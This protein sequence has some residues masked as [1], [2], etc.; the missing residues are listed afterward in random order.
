MP[1]ASVPRAAA[2]A[3]AALPVVVACSTASTAIPAPV[4]IATTTLLARLGTDTVALE[5]YTRTATHMEGTLVTRLPATRIS[6]Y[7]VEFGPNGAPTRATLS[8]RDGSGA[9]LSGGLQSLS[10]RFGRDSA[11]FVGHRSASD[12]SHAFALRGLVLPSLPF[13]Y[14]L[15]EVGLARMS[16]VA[17][18]SIEFAN[19]PLSF[20]TRQATPQAV[21]VVSHDSVRITVNG[22]PLYVRHDGR[23]GIVAVDGARTTFKVLVERVDSLD[24][25]AM[26]RA[27]AQREPGSTP[28]GQASPRDTVQATVG[29][30]HLRIDYG[31]PAPRGR[32]VCTRCGRRL[33]P[34]ATGS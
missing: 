29:A 8:V 13:S 10:V 18:D 11:T 15:Y 12:T 20:D 1:A 6:R 19:V 33:V 16:R 2:V 22:R 7:S 26:A 9:P 34:A 25:E 27:W 5:Q 23:G 28:A 3:L 32:D 31:R 24:L 30:A 14:G 4:P 17:R 21:R